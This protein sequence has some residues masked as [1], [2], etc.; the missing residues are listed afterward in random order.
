[1]Q[2]ARSQHRFE[3]AKTL[4]SFFLDFTSENQVC[5]P[6]VLRGAVAGCGLSS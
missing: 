5:L 2:Q 3:D 6:Q 1:M 4:F